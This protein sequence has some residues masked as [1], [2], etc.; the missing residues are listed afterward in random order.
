MLPTDLYPGYAL[1]SANESAP[2]QGIFIPLASLPA[3]ATA[4]A[5]ELT[6]DAREVKRALDDAAAENLATFTSG[7]GT[8]SGF[9]QVRTINQSLSDTSVR[10]RYQNDYDVT[11]SPS[12]ASMV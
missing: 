10:Y 1:L 4:E 7:G 5:D 6:G 3:L 9:K 12:S 2:S 8:A 11:I